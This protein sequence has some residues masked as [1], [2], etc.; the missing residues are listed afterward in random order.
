MAA[1]RKARK[2]TPADARAVRTTPEEG[3]SRLAPLDYILHVM[4]DPAT[5][6]ER[7][8]EMAKLALPYLHPKAVQIDES[9]ED[10]AIESTNLSDTDVARRIGFILAR[11]VAT[12]PDKL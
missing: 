7:R 4:R 6:P 12:K 11:A 2:P 10:G 3:A 1:R 8:D 9:G 5:E